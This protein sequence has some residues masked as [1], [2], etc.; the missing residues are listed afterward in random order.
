[1]Q[2]GIPKEAAGAS[3]IVSYKQASLYTNLCRSFIVSW[4]LP[5]QRQASSEY[6]NMVSSKDPNC[7]LKIIVDGVKHVKMIGTPN[8]IFFIKL[9]ATAIQRL[10]TILNQYWLGLTLSNF[11]EGSV[12]NSVYKLLQYWVLF[13]L[14][15]TNVANFFPT[16][17]LDFWV[18]WHK[19]Y[20][21][22]HDGFGGICSRCQMRKK[23]CQ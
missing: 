21:P 16:F 15:P 12:V 22:V 18:S 10:R 1:M 19:A 14:K 17:G 11:E 7:P 8:K 4:R 3:L 2:W 9:W 23:K 6:D 13:G 5:G 20:K